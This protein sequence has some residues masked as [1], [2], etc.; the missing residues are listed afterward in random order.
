MAKTPISSFAKLRGE[1]RDIVA[2]LGAFCLFLSTIEYM[3]PKPLPFMRIGISNLPLMLALDL[4]SFRAFLLLTAIKV[5]GQGLVTGSLFSYIFLFSLL[6]SYTSALVMYALRRGLGPRRVGYVGVG[7]LGALVS[8]LTQI[9]LAYVF[10]FGASARYVAPPFLAMGVV[11]G[12]ALGLFCESFAA[13]SSWFSAR[14]AR[15]RSGGE[16]Q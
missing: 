8:N 1:T 3:L 12:V 10:V 13:R 15:S 2:L 14:L 4:L 7:S 11:T 16:A 9:L 6:G 5:V